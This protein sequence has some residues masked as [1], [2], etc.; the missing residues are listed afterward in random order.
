M[1]NISELL[2]KGCQSFREP[3]SQLQLTPRPSR[4]PLKQSKDSPLQHARPKKL[5]KGPFFVSRVPRNRGKYLRLPLLPP[6]LPPMPKERANKVCPQDPI[7]S[8][9]ENLGPPQPPSPRLKVSCSPNPSSFPKH[10]P[11]LPKMQL[12]FQHLL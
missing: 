7:Q 8:S 4:R 5:L 1:N 12:S 2:E 3:R 6:R 9:F 10:A 11:S